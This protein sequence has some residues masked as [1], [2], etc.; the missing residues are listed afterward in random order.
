MCVVT[1]IGHTHSPIFFHRN[2]VMAKKFNV[3]SLIIQ[4]FGLFLFFRISTMLEVTTRKHI[5]INIV[6]NTGIVGAGCG[7]RVGVL[8]GEGEE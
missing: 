6:G 2:L 4:V 8:G 1:K 7:V 3:R 5:V